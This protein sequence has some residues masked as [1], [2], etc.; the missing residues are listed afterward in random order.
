MVGGKD[1]CGIR[2]SDISILSEIQIKSRY[3]NGGHITD[4]WK[5]DK[6]DLIKMGDT[7]LVQDSE[8]KKPNLKP[9]SSC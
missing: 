6:A 9:H 8:C 3:L 7:A 5:A 2:Y 4:G 1:M